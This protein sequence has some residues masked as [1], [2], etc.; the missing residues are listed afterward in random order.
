MKPDCM[1]CR[2]AC[3]ETIVM[4]GPLAAFF[5]PEWR[6]VRG[7]ELPPFEQPSWEIHRSCPELTPEGLCG[8]HETKPR[9]CREYEPGSQACLSAIERRRT[10]EQAREILGER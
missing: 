4:P 9:V 7:R 10:R 8:I 6:R 2:G 1:V 3:C 5:D